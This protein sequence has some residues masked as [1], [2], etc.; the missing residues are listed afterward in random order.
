MYM[1]CN[2][3]GRCRLNYTLEV[4]RDGSVVD[5]RELTG[6][7]HHT[8]GRTPDNGANSHTRLCIVPM[9][10]WVVKLGQ[11]FMQNH[12]MFWCRRHRAGASVLVEDARGDPVQGHRR[13]VPV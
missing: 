7:D 11:I 6:K 1:S 5:T 10:G 13:G 3:L 9:H 12:G 2:R 8:M 4:L